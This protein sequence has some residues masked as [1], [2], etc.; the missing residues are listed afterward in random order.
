MRAL[1]RENPFPSAGHVPLELAV[2]WRSR[3]RVLALV[4]EVFRAAAASTEHGEAARQSG[5]ADWTQEPLAGEDPGYAEVD[6]LAR[7]DEDPPERDRLQGLLGQLRARGYAWGDIAMLATGTTTSCAPPRG[8]TRSP[9]PSSPSAAWT[10]AGRKVASE[11]LALLA[12]LD[13]PTDDLAFATFLLGGIFALGRPAPRCPVADFLFRCRGEQPLYKAFQREFP[14]AWTRLLAGLFRSAGYLPLY[15]LVSEA[16]AAFGIFAAAG[17]EEAALAKLLEKVKKFEGS[18]SNSLREFLG[19][20]GEAG[21]AEEWAIDAPR[22][23]DAC[24]P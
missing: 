22:S 17:E 6:I 20:A 3:P 12:F 19:S 16:C 9:S 10:C 8:S 24:G 11:I 13:S 14:D 15:D 4:R 23:A 7:D 5:L 1:E 2:N 18:G 21:D